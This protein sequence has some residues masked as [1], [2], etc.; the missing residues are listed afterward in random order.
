MFVQ[1]TTINKISISLS[2]TGPLSAALTYFI[3]DWLLYLYYYIIINYN[4]S[5]ISSLG[6]TNSRL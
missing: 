3:S 4:S 1:M 5:I 2:I 6:Y